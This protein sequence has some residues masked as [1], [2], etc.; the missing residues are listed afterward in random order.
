VGAECV[1]RNDA[2]REARRSGRRQAALDDGRGIDRRQLPLNRVVDAGPRFAIVEIA[3]YLRAAQELGRIDVAAD[4]A[5]AL[6]DRGTAAGYAGAR[7]QCPRCGCGSSRANSF[8]MI[9]ASRF[10]S[11]SIC[12]EI[13]F[14][15]SFV[16]ARR[17]CSA[18]R[19]AYS[20]QIC[21][22]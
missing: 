22:I 13:M 10:D 14:R 16:G 2:S 19:Q 7:G 17:S 5:A 20:R 12:P 1:A 21:I 9:S 6:L 11:V 8:V 15:C 3:E 4:I 18:A